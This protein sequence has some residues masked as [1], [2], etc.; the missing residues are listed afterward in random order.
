MTP[1]IVKIVI[2][3]QTI[4]FVS[5]FVFLYRELTDSTISEENQ[6]YSDLIIEQ[7]RI[8]KAYRTYLDNLRSDV[9]ATY[10]SKD[11]QS[12]RRG[13]LRRKYSKDR[14]SDSL[15]Q[16]IRYFF[17]TVTNKQS[18]VI[19]QPVFETFKPKLLWEKLLN[20]MANKALNSTSEL[21]SV[22]NLNSNEK[23][24]EMIS[25]FLQGSGLGAMQQPGNFSKLDVLD[26]DIF[27]YWDII[28]K[29]CSSSVRKST[30]RTQC[31]KGIFIG[32]I[33]RRN[34]VRDFAY[35]WQ[36]NKADS[37][38]LKTYF[39]LM[40]TQDGL[41]YVD[42]FMPSKIHSN[43]EIGDAIN[44]LLQNSSPKSFKDKNNCLHLIRN[45]SVLPYS[46]LITGFSSTNQSSGFLGLSALMSLKIFLSMICLILT[47]LTISL[48][49]SNL[50]K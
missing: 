17:Y 33:D 22:E 24:S 29:R 19:V 8:E 15:D 45:T 4:L 18:E 36:V 7:A 12:L 49:V 40:D 27:I 50:F 25:V 39:G 44:D 11:V 34:S 16:T 1:R 38:G 32:E 37:Q 42:S 6:K 35:Q 20:M 2:A 3:I 47:L 30:G 48:L 28:Y 5:I 14:K 31:V 10:K 26:E 9:V 13:N 43:A 21:S 46:F 23:F 41:T